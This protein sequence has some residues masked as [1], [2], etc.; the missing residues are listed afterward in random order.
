M[1]LNALWFGL[2]HEHRQKN[3]DGANNQRPEERRPKAPDVKSQTYRAGYGARHPQQKGI[4]PE[5]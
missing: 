5:A 3:A 2:R 4:Q 1:C